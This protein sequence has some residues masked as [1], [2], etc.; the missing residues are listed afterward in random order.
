MSKK[1]T[2][3]NLKRTKRLLRYHWTQ[4]RFYER[5]RNNYCL[6]GGLSYIIDGDPYAYC[7]KSDE[8]CEAVNAINDAIGT[9]DLDNCDYGSL[10][11]WN[12]HSDRRKS[13]VI[14]AINLTI[15][16]L[17]KGDN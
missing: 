1:T 10:I 6:V 16:K 3:K 13:E 9:S 2:I 4:A 17:K 12:D 15:K 8:F 7:S 14:D 11:K 5:K